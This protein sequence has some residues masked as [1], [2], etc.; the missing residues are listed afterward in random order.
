MVPPASKKRRVMNEAD[1]LND[2]SVWIRIHGATLKSSDKSI[3]LKGYEINDR[4]INAVQKMLIAQFPSLK[5]LRSTLIQYHL[6][7]WTDK[8]LQ[9]VHIGF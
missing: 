6:G 9:I 1:E 5:G 3:L 4:V 8:Y 2:D 7:R